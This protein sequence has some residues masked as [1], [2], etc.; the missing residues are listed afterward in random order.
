MFREF[1]RRG[2]RYAVLRWFDALPEIEPSEDV[3][4]LIADESLPTALEIL[5][6][7]PGIQLTDV[8]SETG[9]PRSEYCGVAYYPPNVAKKI[10]A[11]AVR[12]KDLCWVPSPADYF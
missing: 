2:V 9:L 1:D 5:H 4:M 12:H 11:G 8:Y 6:S 10:L 3:D 7:Q